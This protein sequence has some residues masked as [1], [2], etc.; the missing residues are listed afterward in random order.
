MSTKTKTF[1]DTMR[2]NALK[3]S[4][5]GG[6]RFFGWTPNGAEAWVSFQLD[7]E[8]LELTV[9]STVN[10]ELLLEEGARLADARVTIAMVS[11]NRNTVEDI[12]RFEKRNQGGDVTP[13]TI[14]YLIKVMNA[15]E[16]KSIKFFDNKGRANKSAFRI[17]SNAIFTGNLDEEKG[18][19]WTDV[20]QEWGLPEGEYFTIDSLPDI[21]IED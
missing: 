17:V 2:E 18:F 15:V 4:H 11:T 21:V 6:K 3:A 7:R 9:N 10:L 20:M 19:R 12:L 13:H 1:N 8:T 16:G 5:F 14:E